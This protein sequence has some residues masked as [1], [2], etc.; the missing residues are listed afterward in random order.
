MNFVDFHKSLIAGWDHQH[1]GTEKFGER[2]LKVQAYNSTVLS[3]T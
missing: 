3:P 1:S 2:K